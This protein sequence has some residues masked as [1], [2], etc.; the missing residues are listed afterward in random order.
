M[1]NR[2]IFFFLFAILFLVSSTCSEEKKEIVKPRYNMNF[3][4]PSP[5]FDA[6]NAYSIIKAQIEF[7]PRNPNSDGHN[8]TLTFLKLKLEEYGG[9]VEL[10]KFEYPGYEN[11]KLFLSNII[12]R[13]NPQETSRIMLCAHWDTRPWADAEQNSER[14]RSPISGANDGAS[15]VGILL[16]VA[17]IISTNNLSYGIDIVLF[18]G[19]DYGR[20]GELFNFCLGSK[21][22]SVASKF[23]Q[24]LFAILVDLVGDKNAIFPKETYSVQFA[25]D[26]V[27]LVWA[28]AK[29][30]KSDKFINLIGSPIYDDHIP[31]NQS[32]IQTINIVD[33]DYVGHNSSNRNYWHTHEDTIDKIGVKT[34]QQVGN[35]L[36]KLLY[37]ISFNGK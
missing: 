18:D 26:V 8:K 2:L 14:K 30:V 17:R 32:G 21:Y 36:I 1:Q 6:D 10:Q 11:E 15:G 16:E 29:E 12:A 5:A 31:L 28:T 23:Q 33:I 22:Y 35:V 9:T 34:L 13:F 4:S 37:S 25:P 20:E 27:E 7:G 19:E 24:P 3:N